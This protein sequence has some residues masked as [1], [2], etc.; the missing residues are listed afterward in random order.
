MNKITDILAIAR[1]EL[2]NQRTLLAYIRTSFFFMGLGLTIIGID[3]FEKLKFLAIPLFMA[4]PVII[5]IGI[6]TY[7][8]EKRKIETIGA[9]VDAAK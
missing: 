8:K 7:Y 5:F 2:A 6:I 3:S 4:S 1:T 9:L